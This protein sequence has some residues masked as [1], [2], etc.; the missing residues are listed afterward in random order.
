MIQRRHPDIATTIVAC[1]QSPLEGTVA[2]RQ[3]LVDAGFI[4]PTW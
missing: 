4:A 3:D 1:F 2:V